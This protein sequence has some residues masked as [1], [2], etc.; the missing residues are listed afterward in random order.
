MRQNYDERQSAE[1]LCG[2]GRILLATGLLRQLPRGEFLVFGA[3]IP[4][5]A[6]T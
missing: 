1:N 5:F 6:P 4:T 3:K 2:K